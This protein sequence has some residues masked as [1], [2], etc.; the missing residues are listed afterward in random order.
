MYSAIGWVQ[1]FQKILKN[2]LEDS[3]ADAKVVL[4]QSY[5]LSLN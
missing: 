5:S 3:L 4:T 1:N 2:Y